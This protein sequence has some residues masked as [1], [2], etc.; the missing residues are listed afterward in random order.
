MNEN[1]TQHNISLI[2]SLL[3]Q[4]QSLRSSHLS[5]EKPKKVNKLLS[6]LDERIKQLTV[7]PLLENCCS[8][9]CHLN[10]GSAQIAAIRA[11]MWG[12]LETSTDREVY[13]R[14]MLSISEGTF[15]TDLDSDSH[16]VRN[17]SFTNTNH[18]IDTSSS[19]L[20]ETESDLSSDEPSS[21]SVGHCQLPG[22]G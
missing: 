8:F 10:F 1:W 11:H 17:N 21:Y 7:N 20:S 15:Q 18:H 5:L 9:N 16:I 14:R 12:T 3:R 2:L 6:S 22:F 19:E 13:L 4:S